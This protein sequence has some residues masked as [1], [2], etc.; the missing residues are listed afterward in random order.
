MVLNI[1]SQADYAAVVDRFGVR[2]NSPWFWRISDKLHGKL[3][4]EEP[5]AWGVLDLNRYEGYY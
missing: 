4:D 1:K 5:I 3:K 2:R